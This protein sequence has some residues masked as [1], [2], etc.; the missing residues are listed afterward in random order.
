MCI[1]DSHDILWMG[2]ATGSRTCIATVLNNSITYNNLEVIESGYGI[3]LRPLALFA[4]E[5]YKNSDLSRFMPKVPNERDYTLKDMLQGARMHKAIAIIQFKLEGQILLR[6]PEYKMDDR[7]LLGKIDYQHKTIDI[8]GVTYSLTDCDFPTVDQNDPYALTEEEALLMKQLKT[9]FQHSER[10]QRHVGF[11]YSKGSL[12]RC[13][14][15]NLLFHGC[16]PLNPD[17][18]LMEFN[19]G[20]QTLS[21]KRLMDYADTI[22]RQGYYAKEDT[23]QKQYGKDFLWFLWCGRNSPLCGRER[24]PPLSGCSS[25]TKIVGWSRKIPI[26]V[27]PMTRPSSPF[28]SGNLDWVLPTPTLSMATCP[29]NQRM[30][31]IPSRPAESSLSSTEDFAGFISPLPELRDTL[32]SI[33]PMASAYALMSPLAAWIT[34]LN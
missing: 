16:I 4:N 7:M 32:S 27:L 24:S 25:M 12:Y 21:G 33:T 30:A 6:H 28:C 19:L 14:N 34:P 15:S 2:A 9:A 26:T 22:A 18:S 31:K 5:V 8:D 23:P 17:G 29:L 20:G 1:R 13:F 3:S 11:L 10:L